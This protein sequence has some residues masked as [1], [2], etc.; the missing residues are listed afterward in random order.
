[1]AAVSTRH[2]GL[3]DVSAPFGQTAKV[4]WSLVELSSA[5]LADVEERANAILAVIIGGMLA[6]WATI[7]NFDPAPRVRSSTSRGRSPSSPSSYTVR[8][9]CRAGG[10]GSH[11][12]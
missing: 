3:A 1:M 12:R 7:A 8:T 9:S 11:V 5:R 2:L 4:A 6:I 10:T